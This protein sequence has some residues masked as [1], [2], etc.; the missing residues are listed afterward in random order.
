MDERIILDEKRSTIVIK[1]VEIEDK[2][3]YEYIKDI[4]E[5]KRIII[6]KSAL[7]IGVIGLK[8]ITTSGELDFVEKE[9]HLMTEEINKMFD[10]SNKTSHLGKIILQIEKYFDEGGSVEELFNPDNDKSPIGKLKKEIKKEFKELRDVLKKEEGKE[11]IID[12][13]TLKGEKFEDKCEKYLNLFVSRQFGDEFERTTTER[14]EISGSKK[15][16][17]VITLRDFPDKKIVIETKDWKTL[18]LPQILDEELNAAMKNRGAS[19]AIFISKNKEALPQKVGWFNEYRGNMLV[20]ALGSSEADTFFP[21]ILNIVYQWAK[22]RITKEV[23]MEEEAL[24]TI[25]EGIN[26]IE[27]KL[28]KFSQI[29]RQCTNIE[30]SS[31]KIREYSEE[32]KDQIGNQ[33]ININ[34]AI[35]N[36]SKK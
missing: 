22:L 17:F 35:K 25:M 6:L 2:D 9:F 36:V 30:D 16:D 4:N 18:T 27:Q 33:L 15:G 13:T 34:L 10:P 7:R 11:E 26:Q 28:E 32:I 8:R 23:T 12:K 14:G 21:Q 1:N 29:K 31:E 20:C 19:Y 3:I 24:E 5:E